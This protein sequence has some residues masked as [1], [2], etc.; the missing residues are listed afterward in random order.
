MSQSR[1]GLRRGLERVLELTEGGK[2]RAQVQ[3]LGKPAFFTTVYPD[4]QYRRRGLLAIS[5]G[6]RILVI[7]MDDQAGE[8]LEAT[9]PKLEELAKLVL[10]RVK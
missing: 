9:R 7:S 6:D 10:P 4:D 3:G 8:P 5:L 1:H 2:Q